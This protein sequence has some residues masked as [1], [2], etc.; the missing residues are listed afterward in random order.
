[1]ADE[2]EKQLERIENA[3]AE[4]IGA[5]RELRDDRA[6]AGAVAAAEINRRLRRFLEAKKQA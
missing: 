3:V 4:I 1:M 2:L 6:A 5:V